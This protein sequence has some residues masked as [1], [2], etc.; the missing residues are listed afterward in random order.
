M[1]NG[2]CSLNI[3]GGREFGHPCTRTCSMLVTFY[4][5]ALHYSRM[6]ATLVT[7]PLLVTTLGCVLRWLHF[8][9]PFLFT[10]LGCALCW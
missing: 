1:H 10:T 8:M 6:G 5:A 7:A 4:G 9:A 2:I 3:A